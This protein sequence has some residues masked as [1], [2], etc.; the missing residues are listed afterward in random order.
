MKGGQ[1]RL[2]F[3]PGPMCIPFGACLLTL[4]NLSRLPLLVQ[5]QHKGSAPV[6]VSAT[7]A[8]QPGAIKVDPAMFAR[9]LLFHTDLTKLKADREAAQQS[10][11]PGTC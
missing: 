7:D 1:F 9:S 4:P 2:G 5:R 11:H 3:S 10:Y 6:T 8:A